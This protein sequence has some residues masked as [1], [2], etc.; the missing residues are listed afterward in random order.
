MTKGCAMPELGF[1]DGL[2]GNV[3]TLGD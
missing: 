2:S 1:D 3:K